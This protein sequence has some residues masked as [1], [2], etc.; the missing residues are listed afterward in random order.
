MWVGSTGGALTGKLPVM[1]TMSR[2]PISFLYMAARSSGGRKYGVRQA[3]DTRALADGL[4]RERLLLLRSWKL[5]AWVASRENKKLRLRDQVE[6]HEQLAQLLS[7]GVPLVEALEVTASAVG[8]KARPLVGRMREMDACVATGAFDRVTIAVYR[9]SERTGDLAGAGKKLGQTA[10]RQMAI[11][12]KAATVM[13]YP[14]VVVTFSLLM[15]LFM[16]TVIVP[17]IVAALESAGVKLPTYSKI[18]LG[19]GI[20]RWCCW[21]HS[22]PWSWGW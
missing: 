9:A 16:L 7:R 22:R 11:T 10:R 17:R 3:R 15:C 2:A 18:I 12:G 4:R 14:A 19:T 20:M 13:M 5:P 1:S 21:G 8:P 6:M